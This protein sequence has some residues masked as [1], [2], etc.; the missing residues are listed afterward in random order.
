MS[1]W[2][3]LTPRQQQIA[4]AVAQGES[5]EAIAR[6]LQIRLTSVRHALTEIYQRL[7]VKGKQELLLAAFEAG[8]LQP[9]P[10]KQG[11]R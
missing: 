3:A 7:G 8:V 9:E 11:R 5:D 2:Q 10:E 6:R 1:R 4:L